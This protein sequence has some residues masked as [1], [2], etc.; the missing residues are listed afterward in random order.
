MKIGISTI[1]DYENYGNR[2]QNYALQEVLVNLGHEVET[3][4]N[5]TNVPKKSRKARIISSLKDGSAIKKIGNR[6][7]TVRIHEDQLTS[8]E[9]RNRSFSNF[10][11]NYINETL[12]EINEKSID[13]FYFKKFD[14]FIIG[15]DQVW[16][17]EFDR[18]SALD[19][20]PYANKT[21]RVISYAA[22]F[23]VSQIPKKY[24]E[25]YKK[26]LLNLNSI[27]VREEAGSKIVHELTSREAK[28]VLDPTM[29][30]EI[31][32]WNTLAETSKFNIGEKKYILT[33]FLG[34]PLKEQEKYIFNYAKEKNYRIF[35]LGK[36]EDTQCWSAG[37]DGF[38]KLFKNAQAIFTDSYHACVFSIIFEKYFEVFERNSNDLSMNSRIDTLLSTFNIN[39]CRY[40]GTEHEKVDYTKVKI[41]LKKEK[42]NSLDFLNSQ[43][44]I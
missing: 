26:G 22:S 24:E 16:N 3:I 35:Q 27:S 4:K 23:G 33:Y 20:I 19:F 11:N 32:V 15:S 37:P 5:N 42:E 39:D 44:K 31:N 18:F 14:L 2:L 10:T 1:I 36:I 28:V 9:N 29:L 25:V 30:V 41:I 21:Q 40:K 6:L 38:V 17:F 8:I 43:I 12:T 13:F 7:K 34:S